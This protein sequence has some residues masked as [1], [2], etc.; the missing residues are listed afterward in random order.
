MRREGG[1]GGGNVRRICS[2]EASRLESWRER[3]YSA[4]AESNEAIRGVKD[5]EEEST[6]ERCTISE[7]SSRASCSFSGVN[8]LVA[9]VRDWVSGDMGLEAS[10]L[11][12]GMD[13]RDVDSP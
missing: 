10:L 6:V 5:G 4:T 8:M 2:L 13:P 3:G 11:S 7:M 12:R 1:G 9:L